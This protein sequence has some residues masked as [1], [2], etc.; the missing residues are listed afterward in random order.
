[1]DLH[2][3]FRHV[4]MTLPPPQISFRREE[5]QGPA[6]SIARVSAKMIAHEPNRG[7]KGWMHKLA[8]VSK[9][10]TNEISPIWAN[11]ERAKHNCKGVT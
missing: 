2:S 6:I 4:Q 3:K 8:H 9:E 11:M 10:D 7:S 5:E 1:M